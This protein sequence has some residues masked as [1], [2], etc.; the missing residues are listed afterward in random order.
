MASV[1]EIDS[2]SLESSVSEIEM[3]SEDFGDECF[4]AL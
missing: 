4:H 3:L 2:F 1:R